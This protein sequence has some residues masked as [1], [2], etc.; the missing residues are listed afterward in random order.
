MKQISILVLAI[1]ISGVAHAE[2]EVQSVRYQVP[3]KNSRLKKYANFKIEKVEEIDSEGQTE[4]R[5][6]LPL[7]LTG[8]PNELV[9]IGNYKHG[10]SISNLS[11]A[12]GTM[13]CSEGLS[14][15]CNVQFSNLKINEPARL[16]ILK[17]MS[18]S[19]AELRGRL[20]VA[21]SFSGDPGGVL[22][23]K[24]SYDSAQ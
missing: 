19:S 4:I 13:M 5:Y 18:G 6:T 3:V 15:I 8:A 22:I 12:N 14:K 20:A 7:E 1:A 16:N 23:Y 9:F 10:S 21:R 2:L 17:S 11:G 24:R